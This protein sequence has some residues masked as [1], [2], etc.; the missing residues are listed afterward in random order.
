MGM[1]KNMK[2]AFKDSSE[3]VDHITAAMRNLA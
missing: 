3:V 2:G 1:S